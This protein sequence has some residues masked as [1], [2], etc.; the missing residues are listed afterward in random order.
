MKIKNSLILSMLVVFGVFTSGG[1]VTAQESDPIAVEVGGIGMNPLTQSSTVLLYS[2][3]ENLVLPIFIGNAEAG[4][5]RR[6]LDGVHTPRPMTHDLISNLLDVFGGQLERVIVSD[7]RDSTYFALLV[8]RLDDKTIRVDARPSD[9]I[10]VAL[11]QGALIEVERKVMDALGYIQDGDE[12]VPPP[13][14]PASEE[15]P[16]TE[17]I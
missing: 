2:E 14:P 9:A 6:Y 10:A 11:K 3:S 12:F 13:G 7:F 17:W 4:A 1:L 16:P 8:I 15:I 5:I